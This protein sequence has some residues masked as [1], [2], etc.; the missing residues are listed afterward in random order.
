MKFIASKR[1]RLF[2]LVVFI[3]LLLGGCTC[4]DDN[5]DDD[6][7]DDDDAG[8]DDTDE[9]DVE[10]CLEE[11][12]KWLAIAE[13]DRARLSF[14]CVLDLEPD[15]EEGLYGLALADTIHLIDV[16]GILVDY[17]NVILDFGGPVK[18]GDQA[19]YDETDVL[20]RLLQIVMNGLVLDISKELAE[21]AAILQE[22]FKDPKY[23]HEGIPLV[24]DFELRDTMIGEFDRSFLTASQSFSELFSGLCG[25]LIVM[26]LDM[27]I[28]LVFML[29]NV[30]FEDT[31]TAVGDLIDIIILMLN[32]PGHPELFTLDEEGLEL[33]TSLGLTIGDG[34]DN[35]LNTW[36]AVG[37]ETDDQ[38]DDVMGYVDSNSNALWDNTEPFFLPYFEILE[39]EEMN[40]LFM[41]T[42]VARE[43]RNAFWDLTFKDVDPA[44]PNPLPLAA[45]NP[46]LE[47]LGIPGFIPPNLTLAVGEWYY[48]PDPLAVR[49]FIENLVGVLDP[50]FPGTGQFEM[51]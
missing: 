41:F 14:Q 6:D 47:L 36:G 3:S 27:D 35:Y 30:D 51:D 13:G 11:G 15:N 17:V 43:F 1:Y 20:D 31:A 16:L 32:D 12:R 10:E 21:T 18:A 44:N 25:H 26:S 4:D 33:Y 39:P 49:N 2:Y 24:V 7:D 22:D 28:S 40:T 48:D 37:S 23:I 38:A 45:L 46:V 50:L 19:K 29:G 5:D 9:P 42:G 8:D 34:F